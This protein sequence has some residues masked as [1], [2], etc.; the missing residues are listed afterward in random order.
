MMGNV[1]VV[2]DDEKVLEILEQSLGR[3][4]YS[5]RVARD[6]ES[7]LNRYDEATPDVVVLDLMLPDMSG[8]DVFKAIR[9]RPHG[10]QTPVLFVSADSDPETRVSSLD[11]GAEDFLAKPFSLRELNT[12]VERALDRHYRT[13]SLEVRQTKLV[14]RIGEQ[15]E[16]YALVN[17]ELKKQ[18]LSMKTLF[19]VSQDLNRRVDLDELIN[20]LALSVIGELQV[21]SMAFYYRKQENED[22]FSLQGLKGFDKDRISDLRLGTNSEFIEWVKETGKPRKIARNGESGWASRL[23]DIRL[24]VF[25]YVTPVIV[26]QKLIGLV[27]TGPK[28]TG[29]E[30]LPFELD[31]LSSLCNSAGT[32]VE[33]LR[34]LE[35]L[36]ATYISTVKALMSIVEAKDAYTKGHTQ[37][38]ADYALALARKMRLGKKELRDL[39]FAAV[40][41][42]I[43]KLVIY[44]KVL[45]KPGSLSDE[46]WELLKS[47]PEI[48]AS[49]IENMEFLAAAVPLVRH[50]HERF[51]GTGYPGGLKGDDI[52]L[53]ARII[54]VADSFDAMTTDRAYRHALPKEIA[55]GTM[56]SKAGTQFDPQVVEAFIELIEVDGYR[57]RD[58]SDEDN[59]NAVSTSRTTQK[60]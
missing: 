41:H 45:N 11:D 57:A 36:Q 14:S 59:V 19:A 34:L 30:Y 33:H 29:K 42:D 60:T 40:L 2:D 12:K 49:I 10:E 28:I 22:L 13:R 44:E 26:K 31:I 58:E 43:G 15:E 53:G 39:A 47:H 16:N 9:K 37:R 56:K 50:H 23:P 4:G 52:P 1:L 8:R 55:L 38:V 32:G 24:A 27:F 51:D 18:I 6:G 20:G 54:A 25:E 5:V 35:A 21:S 3:R 17:R 46:E 7:A 48:G